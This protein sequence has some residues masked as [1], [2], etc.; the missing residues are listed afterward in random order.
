MIFTVEVQVEPVIEPFS[1]EHVADLDALTEDGVVSEKGDCRNVE[2]IDDA[3]N[4]VLEVFGVLAHFG[5]NGNVRLLLIAH[6]IG[7]QQKEEMGVMEGKVRVVENRRPLLDK[8][9][10]FRAATP[11]RN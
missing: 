7:K 11:Q 8:G 2:S 5:T 6:C 1:L 9:I 4:Y 3:S 10:K